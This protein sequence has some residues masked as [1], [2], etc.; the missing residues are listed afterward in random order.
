MRAESISLRQDLQ[1]GSGSS[2]KSTPSKTLSIGGRSILELSSMGIPRVDAG[3]DPELRVPSL[4]DLS[5]GKSQV[6]FTLV[7]EAVSAS[8]LSCDL[9]CPVAVV[10][11][12]KVILMCSLWKVHHL[13]LWVC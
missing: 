3:L 4:A 5:D 8:P 13:F 2:S 1:S 9:S 10:S 7:T 6:I 11:S 12:Q